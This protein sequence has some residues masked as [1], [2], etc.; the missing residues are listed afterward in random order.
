MIV[1]RQWYGKW[2]FS[3][4]CRIKWEGIFLFGF[5]PIYIHQI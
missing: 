2:D 4:H 1:K 5:I 3:T